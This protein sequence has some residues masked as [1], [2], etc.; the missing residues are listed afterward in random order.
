MYECAE[1]ALSH[2]PQF[3]RVLFSHTKDEWATPPDLLERLKNEF[4]ELFDPCPISWKPGDPDG[5]LIDWQKVTFV[6]PPY[7]NWQ[8]W[9]KK[10]Y[11]EFLNGNTVIM[12]LP[13]WTDTKAFHNYCMRA[14][15]IRFIKG[16]LRFGDS[17]NSA[18]F[19]SMLVI[20]KV[21]WPW[22]YMRVQVGSYNND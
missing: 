20:F 17:K 22:E 13:A 3:D 21:P 6:N 5:L 18:P 8:L 9:A 15:E 2:Q 11:K 1:E 7:S 4:G 19:P 12:L 10:A 14:T 16:R